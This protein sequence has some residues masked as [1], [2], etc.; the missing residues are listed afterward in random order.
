MLRTALTGTHLLR[1]GEL[2]TDL[3]RLLDDY[4]LGDARDLVRAKQAGERVAA[5]PALLDAWRPR[6][7]QI[8]G[9]FDE[10]YASSVLPE[11]PPHPE[12][13]EA[14]LVEARRQRL[15]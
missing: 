13:V 15:K 8:L 9:R 7:G 3:T 1:T 6:L 5:D 14:W 11:E 10:A 12:E 2:E 4:A